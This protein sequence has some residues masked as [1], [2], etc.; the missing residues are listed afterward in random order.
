M[1]HDSNDSD[2]TPPSSHSRSANDRIVI[3]REGH[4]WFSRSVRSENNLDRFS[5]A[6]FYWHSRNRQI[7]IEL[8]TDGYHADAF[9]LQFNAKR[10]SLPLIVPDFFV[11]CGLDAALIA[12]S[13]PYGTVEVSDL[14]AETDALIFTIDL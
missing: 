2:S 3:T 8:F 7:G 5:R 10:A 9:Q 6:A 1:N 4:V 12:G 13:H 14:D 11:E